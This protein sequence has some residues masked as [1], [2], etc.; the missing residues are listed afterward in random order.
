M[1]I[2]PRRLLILIAAMLFAG[3]AQTG[4]AQSKTD[5]KIEKKRTEIRK[6][7]YD[8]LSR[9]YKIQPEAKRSIEKAAGY[10]VF[11]D[12]GVKILVSGSGRGQGLAVNNDTRT[13]T[14]MKM[15]ELQVG[16]GF[17]V[18]KFKVIFVFD[19]DQALQKFVESGW[20]FGGQSDAAIKAG[21][22]KGAS[23][24]GAASVSDGVWMY[25]LTDKGLALEITMKGT[26]YYK[27]DDLNRK[28]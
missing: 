9:L 22:G 19:T 7:A 26:K 5:P 10:A 8:T 18:K 24:A 4:M 15:F 11:T 16:L 6:M 28:L 13:E 27:D 1:R 3:T 21:D 2:L 23:I 20:E 14:F 25:Q 12:K 17:G